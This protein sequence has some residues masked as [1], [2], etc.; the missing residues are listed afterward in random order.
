M[1]IA[2]K[3]GFC[4]PKNFPLQGKHLQPAFTNHYSPIAN[5][6][7][8]NRN[9]AETGLPVTLSK[10]TTVVLSNRNK[11]PPPGGVPS[12]LLRRPHTRLSTRYIVRIEIA[13]TLSKQTTEAISTRYKRPPPGGV[14]SELTFSGRKGFLTPNAAEGIPFVR[15]PAILAPFSTEGRGFIPSISQWAILVPLALAHPRKL[16]VCFKTRRNVKRQTRS[17][18]DAMPWPTPMHMVHSA[19]RDFVACNW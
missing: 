14:P 8:S 15:C 10:Q 1:C 17:I 18:I 6:G 16:C 12:G 4:T 2:P 3:H 9:K 19:Y 11:K 7:L 13:V 5:R